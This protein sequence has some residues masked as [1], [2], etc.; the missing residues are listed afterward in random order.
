M[1]Q[2]KRQTP[3]PATVT[4]PAIAPPPIGPVV[5]DTRADTEDFVSE[6]QMSDRKFTRPPRVFKGQTLAEYSTGERL[7][8]HNVMNNGDSS[9]MLGVSLVWLL[10]Q[11]ETC[12]G[13]AARS[14]DDVE[15]M[16]DAARTSL[17]IM[18]DNKPTCRA[19]IVTFVSKLTRKEM[20]QAVTMASEILAEADAEDVETEPEAPASAGAAALPNAILTQPGN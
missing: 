2:P 10:I 8:W 15:M 5:G 1:K 9:Q 7:L 20:N 12:R 3:P 18:T 13:I 11:L 16:W 14:T 17:L 19:K 4:P 6:D